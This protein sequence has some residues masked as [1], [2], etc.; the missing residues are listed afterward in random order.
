MFHLEGRLLVTIAW[1]FAKPGQL[2]REFIAGRR[3][4]QLNPLRLY[5]FV[6]V[7]FFLGVSLLNRGHLID[8]NRR[9]VDEL[10]ARIARQLSAENRRAETPA[11][12]AEQTQQLTE[13]LA[14]S[15]KRG[16]VDPQNIE[17]A[18]QQALA[19]AREE[20][21]KSGATGSQ[22]PGAR[23]TSAGRPASL[24]LETDD[25]IAHSLVEKFKSVELTVGQVWDAIEQRIPTLLFLG[26][27]VF[28][29]LLKL[30]FLCLR[31]YYIEHLVF[32]LHLHTWAFL[33]L[34][35]GNGYLKL[36]FLSGETAGFVCTWGLIVWACW[37]V[38]YSFRVVYGQSWFAV[39]AKFAALLVLH[40]VLLVFVGLLLSLA[41]LYWLAIT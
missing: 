19:V 11:L 17:G 15:I 27:P 30:F 2:T 31:R 34:M 10:Q 3:Q 1:L 4:R 28:A 36:A 7:L 25:S 12:S 23:A 5:L 41:T 24:P 9:H 40:G 39:T 37:S 29:L 18:I 6:S 35:V 21:V 13:Q 14:S 26:V 33:V 32:S 20:A 22:T 16:H 8:F 38:A